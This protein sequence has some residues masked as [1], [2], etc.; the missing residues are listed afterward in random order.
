MGTTRLDANSN[1]QRFSLSNFLLS[2][3]LRQDFLQDIITGDEKCVVCE[4][5]TRKCQ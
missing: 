4:I 3:F 1:Q 5:H 2:C